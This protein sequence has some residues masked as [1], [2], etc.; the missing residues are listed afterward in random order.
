MTKIR[1]TARSATSGAV[2]LHVKPEDRRYVALRHIQLGDELREPGQLVTA[3]ELKGRN[4]GSMIR[5]GQLQQAIEPTKP[6]AA[7]SRRK[8]GR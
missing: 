7:S 1:T 5:H 6:K 4:I 8:A 2:A 3:D